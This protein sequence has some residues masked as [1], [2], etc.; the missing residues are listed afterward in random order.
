[1][2]GDTVCSPSCGNEEREE[3]FLNP[4]SSSLYKA[5]VLPE[6]F[7]AGKRLIAASQNW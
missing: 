1:M 7:R 5:V 2:N 4:K 3:E 6:G